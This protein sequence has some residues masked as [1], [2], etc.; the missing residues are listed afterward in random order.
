MSKSNPGWLRRLWHVLVKPSARYSVLALL[1]VGGLGG[2][3]FWG[4]FHTAME[5]SN[6]MAFCTGCHEMRDTVYVE[7][8]ETIHYANRTGVQAT[9]SDCHVPRAWGP[10]VVR[11]I[12]ATGEVWGKIIGVIDTKEKFEAKRLEM[13]MSQ[14]AAMK[15]TDSRECRNCHSWE[16]MS[17]DIQKGSVYK[18]HVSGR[19]AGKTCIDCHKGIAHELPK[20]YVDPEDG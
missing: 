9:C 1:V 15:K 11:K 14:W 16:A 6:T 12:Q 2:V 18:K 13:A 4:G 20:G 5:A 19:Q 3:L 17:A 7:Y 10:K 8:K